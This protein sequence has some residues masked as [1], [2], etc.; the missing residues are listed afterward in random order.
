MSDPEFEPMSHVK[1]HARIKEIEALYNTHRH[2]ADALRDQEL[3]R[4]FYECKWTQQAIAQEMGK[5][6]QWVSLHLRFGAYL[7]FT[8]DRCNFKYALETLTEWRFRDAWRAVGKG[9]AK[10]T[11]DGRFERV[12]R[13]LEEHAASSVPKNY[14]NLVH[15]PGLKPVLVEL[16]SREQALGI[17]EIIAAVREKIPGTD[18]PQ[19]T[20][21][22]GNL[23]QHP[24]RGMVL[25]ETHYGKSHRYRLAHRRRPGAPTAVV[26]PEDFGNAV[27]DALPLIKACI[28]MLKRPIAGREETVMHEYL[29]RIQQMLEG[30]LK[31][32]PVA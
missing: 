30:L 18:G 8:T 10:E 25:K 4:L 9:H 20:K 27:I 13:W 19:V 7:H 22:I 6:Q 29:W 3:A 23:R 12:T 16:L 17:A 11:Q 26:N 31:N 32:E 1:F 5:S 15:K 21:A 28:K 24:P 2:G 14:Q